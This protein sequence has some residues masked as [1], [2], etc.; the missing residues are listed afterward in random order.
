MEHFSL[1]PLP[2]KGISENYVN[3]VLHRIE[4]ALSVQEDVGF[5]W[6]Y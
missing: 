3:S 5:V 1:A 6:S 2:P 4:S